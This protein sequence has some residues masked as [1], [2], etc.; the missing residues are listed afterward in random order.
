VVAL[1][2]PPPASRLPLPLRSLS[3]TRIDLSTSGL[4]GS[5]P[6]TSL[7]VVKRSGGSRA[8]GRSAGGSAVAASWLPFLLVPFLA[9]PCALFYFDISFSCC[10]CFLA[11]WWGWGYGSGGSHS[12]SRRPAHIFPP[13]QIRQAREQIAE[14]EAEQEVEGVRK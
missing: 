14:Q 5:D 3:S 11:A 6:A 2:P 4:G 7:V 1:W 8:S 9:L 13:N 12:P 10:F